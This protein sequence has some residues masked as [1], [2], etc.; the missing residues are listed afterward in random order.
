MQSTR[1]PHT[2]CCSRGLCYPGTSGFT[3]GRLKFTKVLQNSLELWKRRKNGTLFGNAWT[4]AKRAVHLRGEKIPHQ[5][6]QQ[7]DV[8]TILAFESQT[9]PEIKKKIKQRNKNQKAV[10]F[11]AGLSLVSQERNENK[12]LTKK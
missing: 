2:G 5:R 4:L 8:P 1:M 3:W 7:Y 12:T 9:F 6:Q 10:P 11:S